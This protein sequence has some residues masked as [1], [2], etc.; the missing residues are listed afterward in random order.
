MA[1]DDS[2][3]AHLV[4]LITRGWQDNPKFRPTTSEMVAEI[5]CMWKFECHSIVVDTEVGITSKNLL[6]FRCY[7]IHDVFCVNMCT[8][9][10]SRSSTSRIF[11]IS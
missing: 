9:V 10:F 2:P 8:V 7:D 3:Y 5:E 11:A 4:A 1:D 6:F